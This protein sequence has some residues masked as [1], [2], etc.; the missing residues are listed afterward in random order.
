MI[1]DSSFQTLLTLGN[2]KKPPSNIH[3][4]AAATM[5]TSHLNPPQHIEQVREIIMGCGLSQVH[6]HLERIENDLAKSALASSST[7]CADLKQAHIT[8][9]EEC[10]RL[11]LDDSNHR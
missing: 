10:Q 11:R 4:L 8:L 6:A 2:G 5:P 9:Q 3:Q 1:E 7:E